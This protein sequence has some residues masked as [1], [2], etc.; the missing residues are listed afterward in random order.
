MSVVAEFCTFQASGK[1]EMLFSNCRPGSERAVEATIFEQN[2]P[3]EGSFRLRQ[4]SDRVAID[5]HWPFDLSTDE[6]IDLNLE[7]EAGEYRRAV[8]EAIPGDT[9]RIPALPTGYLQLRVQSDD[10]VA[11]SVS[12]GHGKSG[13]TFISVPINVKLQDLKF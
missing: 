12:S 10:Q 7:V 1:T 13:T 8:A 11:I 2:H 5:C 3:V 6:W 4:V 9:I